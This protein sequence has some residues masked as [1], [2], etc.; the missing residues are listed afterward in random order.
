MNIEVIK[1]EF[2]RILDI[3]WTPGN[4]NEIGT[5]RKHR[6]TVDFNEYVQFPP[7]DQREDSAATVRCR[8]RRTVWAADVRFSTGTCCRP[9]PVYCSGMPTVCAVTSVVSWSTNL[10]APASYVIAMSTAPLTSTGIEHQTPLHP[11]VAGLLW[12]CF[13]PGRDLRGGPEGPGP[14]PPTNRGRP[15]K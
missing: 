14:R 15:T 13:G 3:I 12:I 4:L 10:R 6:G 2:W 11:F 8:V 9:C 5:N 1:S 7:A